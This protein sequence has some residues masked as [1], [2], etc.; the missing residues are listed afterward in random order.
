MGGRRAPTTA[1]AAMAGVVLLVTLLMTWAATSGPG[2]VLAGDGPSA[3]P[4]TQTP[5]APPGRRSTA[6]APQARDT[7]PPNGGLVTVIKAVVAVLLVVVVLLALGAL[8]LLLRWLW[9]RWELRRRPPPPPPAVDF[10]VVGAPARVAEALARDAGAQR[11]ALL[12]GSVRN[13]IVECW[14]RFEERAGAVGVVREE[15][16]TSSEFVLRVLDLADADSR[17]VAR[18]AALYREARFSDHPL[19]EVERAEALAAL[20]EIHRGLAHAARVGPVAR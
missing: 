6:P 1:V 18:L 10:D 12:G 14:R 3:Q 9:E 11:A 5:T 2:E 20:E 4:L 17:P 15:W 19:G 13:G 16:E 8:A 7:T